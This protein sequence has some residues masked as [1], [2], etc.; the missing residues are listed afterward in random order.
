MDHLSPSNAAEPPRPDSSCGTVE[1]KAIDQQSY[2]V[3]P[4]NPQDARPNPTP[5]VAFVDPPK[6]DASKVDKPKQAHPEKTL[7][8]V[9]FY[10]SL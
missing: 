10:K 3:T 6:H 8:I 9:S 1:E 4:V 7:N 2:T 5:S